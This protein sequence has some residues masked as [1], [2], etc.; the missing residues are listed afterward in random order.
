IS[1]EKDYD[2]KILKS[3]IEANNRQKTLMVEKIKEAVGDLS[4]KTLGILGLSFKPNTDDMRDAPSIEIINALQ[5]SGAKIKAYDPAAMEEAKKV[6]KDIEYCD[7]PYAIAQGT[8]AMIILTE[9][10]QFRNLDLEKIKSLLKSPIFI[11]LR[12]VYEPNKIKNLGFKYVGVG[13]K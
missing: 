13:R 12:N 5:K 9:W 2:F 8:D 3:V 11:D 10:N 6:L 1:R 4:G 7:D